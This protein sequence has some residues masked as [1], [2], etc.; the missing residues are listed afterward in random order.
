MEGVAARRLEVRDLVAGASV[1]LVLVP[2]SVAY[3]QLAGMPPQHGLYA[4][5]L[6]AVAAAFF[7]S[8]PYLQTGPVAVTSL[9]TFGALE[10]LAS[11]GSDDYVALG[12]LLALVVGVA[13]LTVGLSRSGV[14]AYLMSHPVLLGFTS[15]VGVLIVSWQ[16]PTTLGVSAP[17]EHFLAQAWWALTHPGEWKADAIAIS[18]MVLALM[19]A[20]RRVHPLFPGVLVAAALAIAYSVLADYGGPTV[21]DLPTGLPELTLSYP[22]ESLPSL[23]VPGLV[24]A[25]VGFAEAASIARTF[26]AVER[27]PWDPNREFVSQGVANL[28]AGVTGGFPVGGSF[29]RSALNRRAGARTRWSGAVT[30]LVLLAFLPFAGSLSSLPRAALGAILIAAVAGLIRLRSLFELRRY[31]KAQFL[32]GWIT[33]AATLVFSPHL[34]WGVIVGVG[35]AIGVHLWRELTLDVDTWI[36]GDTLHLELRGVLWFATVGRLEVSFVRLLAAHPESRGLAVHMGGVGRLD[37]SG[38]LALKALLAD[39]EHAGLAVRLEGV[40]PRAR[41]LLDRV[42]GVDE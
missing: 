11:P 21:G 36:T 15:A 17:R 14:I 16:L 29:S 1:A 6:P 31:P 12:F 30:G 41:R 34:E 8:S 39:A 25:L 28:T 22:W 5:A 4:A 9:L 19:L 26:A 38:A 7:A 32:I 2:Q 20:G 10:T 18:V 27:K 35:T 37:L 3:A 23:L 40:P 42:M 33:F 24:I 13:R